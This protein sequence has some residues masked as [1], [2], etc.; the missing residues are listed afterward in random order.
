MPREP[1]RSPVIRLMWPVLR[2]YLLAVS[3]LSVAT[4]LAWLLQ[5][6]VS[7]PNLVLLFVLAAVAVAFLAGR[8]P[9][10]LA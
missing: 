8:G 5:P 10:V 4:L 9:A 1:V 3:I 2:P 7:L 6:Y